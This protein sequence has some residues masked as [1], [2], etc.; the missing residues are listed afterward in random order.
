[1][2]LYDICVILDS[3]NTV[4]A[5]YVPGLAFGYR[6]SLLNDSNNS[7]YAVLFS[8]YHN[9]ESTLISAYFPQ[10]FQKN[11]KLLCRARLLGHVMNQYF[12]L[13]SIPGSGEELRLKLSVMDPEKLESAFMTAAGIL[14][15]EFKIGDC[16]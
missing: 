16:V 4:A 1:M 2:E 13:K 11:D 12:G 7:K 15:C 14:K 10:Y 3:L 6:E 8:L 9:R 5:E